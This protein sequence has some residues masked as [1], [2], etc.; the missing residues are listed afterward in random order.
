[1]LISYLLVGKRVAVGVKTVRGPILINVE[2]C[3]LLRFFVGQFSVVV[4][5]ASGA[6]FDRAKLVHKLSGGDRP[7]ALHSR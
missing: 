7:P 5:R 4:L 2:A 6:S 3:F 1:M